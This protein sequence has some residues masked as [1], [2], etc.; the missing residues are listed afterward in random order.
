[1][2]KL[3]RFTDLMQDPKSSSF[4]GKRQKKLEKSQSDLKEENKKISNSDIKDHINSN[5]KQS[6]GTQKISPEPKP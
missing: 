1:M 2:L 3:A 6:N 4:D 5:L